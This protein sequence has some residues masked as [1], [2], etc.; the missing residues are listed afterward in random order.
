MANPK[1]KKKHNDAGSAANIFIRNLTKDDHKMLTALREA[2]GKT[3][4]TQAVMASC[5]RY[6][7][8][9]KT[10]EELR[11]QLRIQQ[12]KNE[13]LQIQFDHLGK[14]V[15]SYFMLDDEKKNM[16]ASIMST[17]TQNPEDEEKEHPSE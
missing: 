14:Q 5:Y 10:T 1:K 7:E 17:I 6:L 8:L 15:T 3:T 9:L 11:Q 4:N 12:T 16:Q 2:V 13:R